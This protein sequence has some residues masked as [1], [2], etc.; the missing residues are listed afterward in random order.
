MIYALV[1]TSLICIVQAFYLFKFAST[2]LRTEDSVEE[3]LDIIDN[4]YGR[5]SEILEKPLFYDSAEVRQILNELSN[6]KEALLYIANVMAN[7]N[8][9]TEKEID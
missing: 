7:N 2:I 1:F 6:S 5:I 3:S 4:S 9:I 8:E